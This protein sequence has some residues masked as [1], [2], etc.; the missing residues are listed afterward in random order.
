[1]TDGVKTFPALQV[2]GYD[3][4]SA[5][6]ILYEFVDPPPL[7]QS[8]VTPVEVIPVAAK[9]V[10]LGGVGRSTVKVAPDETSFGVLVFRAQTL[11]EYA[12][13]VEGTL[14]V[15]E[16]ELAVLVVP[17]EQFSGAVAPSA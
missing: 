3:E 10:G 17:I 1:L 7:D 11:N 16:A 14:T 15:L 5:Y 8:S 9:A 2:A 13:C 12:V 4:P 6:A